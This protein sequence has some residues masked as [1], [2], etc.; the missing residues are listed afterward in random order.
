MIPTFL[1]STLLVFA[2]LSVVPGGPLDRA[3]DKMRMAS[4]GSG[5]EVASGGDSMRDDSGISPEQLEMLKKQFG[6]DKPFLARYLI[7]L[8]LYPREIDSEVVK[9]GDMFRET[10]RRVDLGNNNSRLIQRHVK[11]ESDGSGGIK[12]LK[13]GVGGDYAFQHKGK[14]YPELPP[15]SSIDSW[16]TSNDWAVNKQDDGSFY[17]AKNKISGLLQGDMGTSFE[18]SQPV[19]KLIRE[20]IPISLYFGLISFFLTYAVCIPLGI[21]KAIRHNTNFD[22][23]TSFV[24]FIGYSIP[25]YAL[26]VLLLLLFASGKVMG[27]EWFPMG[28]FRSLDYDSLSFF[29]K[30]FDQ[31]KHTVLPVICYMVGSFATL[32]ILMKNSLL[33]NLSLD[34]VRTAFAKGLPE[35]KVIFKHAVRNSLIPIA[36]GI[37]GIV[38]IFLSGSYLMELVFNID[39]IGL[40]S[41]KAITTMDYP[42]FMGFLALSVLTLLIGN[43]ISDLLYVLI[44]PRIKFD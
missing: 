14:S 39:G 7:W 9:P 10:V 31:I 38:G 2:I 22:V 37:G 26:G 41:F 32:T 43:L 17:L 36:T 16:T 21:M 35:K 15:S 1:G 27:I 11:V 40:L 25:G 19:G 3:I 33:E 29:G 4:M 18:H 23:I 12:L 5:E 6:L 13:S 42:I 20:R 28:N 30:I 24:I 44:D 34:Y 8:G